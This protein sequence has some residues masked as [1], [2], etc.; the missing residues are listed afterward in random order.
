MIIFAL[1]GVWDVEISPFLRGAHAV[2]DEVL[3]FLELVRFLLEF[4]GDIG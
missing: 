4:G 2:T 1:V 3:Y